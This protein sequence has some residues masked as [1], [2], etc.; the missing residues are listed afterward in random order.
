M[1]KKTKEPQVERTEKIVPPPTN[2]PSYLEEEN[3]FESVGEN[4]VSEDFEKEFTKELNEEEEEIDLEYFDTFLT[5]EELE[6]HESIL[7]NLRASWIRAKIRIRNLNKIKIP[8]MIGHFF[9]E[10]DYIDFKSP[11]NVILDEEIP[12]VLSIFIWKILG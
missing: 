2:E 11:I 8:C 7:K 3:E 1:S 5:R 4:E 9:K 12:E 10:Q 6:Y